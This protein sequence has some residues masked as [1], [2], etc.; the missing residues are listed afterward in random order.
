[1]YT[2]IKHVE[3]F[4]HCRKFCWAVLATAALLAGAWGTGLTHAFSS[5][6]KQIFIKKKGARFRGPRGLQ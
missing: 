6:S 4:H 1:M 3:P 2:L 5:T